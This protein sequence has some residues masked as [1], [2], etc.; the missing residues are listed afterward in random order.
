MNGS[1]CVL[2]KLYLQNQAVDRIQPAGP[3]MPTPNRNCS[4]TVWLL[5]TLRESHPVTRWA[6]LGFRKPERT[7]GPLSVDPSWDHISWCPNIQLW[8]WFRTEICKLSSVDQIWP[9]ACFYM[10]CRALS[11]ETRKTVHQ[12]ESSGQAQHQYR[13]GALRGV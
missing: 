4:K 13:S 1:S 7:D 2:I 12:R 3:S 5:G 9:S 11:K 10:S 8:W 6:E